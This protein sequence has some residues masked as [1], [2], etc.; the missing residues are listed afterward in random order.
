[1]S[2]SSCKSISTMKVFMSYE[3]QNEFNGYSFDPSAFNYRTPEELRKGARS[4][5]FKLAKFINRLFEYHS[6]ILVVR[7]DLGYRQEFA[8]TMPIE[9]VQM[10]RD[11]LLGDRRA[12]P[13]VFD[14]LLGYAWC[15]EESEQG[16][17]YHYHLLAFYH[18]AD[19]RQDISIGLAIGNRWKSITNSCG[20]C[21]VSNF[22]KERLR[23]MGCLGIGMINRTDIQLRI[24]LIEKV[25]AYMTKKCTVFDTRSG[26]TESGEFRSFGKSWMPKPLDPSLPRRGRPR[27]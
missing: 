2:Q 22:D 24:N 1:M 14:G 19:H 17:G 6:R 18:G 12:Y 15:L 11:Q 5:F 23:S 26:R 16:G 7:V 4:N 20:Q 25:A 13:E 3:E 27:Q 10:H 8:N 21:Y 9:I